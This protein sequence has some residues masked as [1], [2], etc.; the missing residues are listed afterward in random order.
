MLCSSARAYIMGPLV[1]VL[2]LTPS[3]FNPPTADPSFSCSTARS[4]WVMRWQRKKRLVAVREGTFA[5]TQSR[6]TST[7]TLR[8]TICM[9]ICA[10][11]Y[12]IRICQVVSLSF[13]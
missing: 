3:S 11:M 6:S 1:L 7:T 10:H 5:V 4:P 12:A 9:T 2:L 13:P 8:V